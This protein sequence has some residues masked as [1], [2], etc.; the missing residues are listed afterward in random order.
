M[1]GRAINDLRRQH[2]K[3]TVSMNDYEQ[4][5]F[6]MNHSMAMAERGELYHA[7]SWLRG[8]WAEAVACC[9]NMGDWGATEHKLIFE[10]LNGDDE[11]RSILIDTKEVAYGMMF[12]DNMVYL[13]V[14]GR[15]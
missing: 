9:S 4:N 6:C 5:Q 3:H 10:L 15:Y 8:D 7:D 12:R 14:R 2:G 13:T 11:H 1:V